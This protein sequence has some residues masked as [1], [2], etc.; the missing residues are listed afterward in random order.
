M[1]S[2]PGLSDE[3]A[4]ITTLVSQ[5][6]A[7]N[8]RLRSRARSLLLLHDGATPAEVTHETSTSRRS[9]LDL[10][11]R[12]R[13]GGLCSALL[14]THPSSEGRMWLTLSPDGPPRV[15]LKSPLT[16]TKRAV[17]SGPVEVIPRH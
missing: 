3:Q 5:N 2:F 12:F 13:S 8:S 16:I 15:R 11:Q 10:I 7:A 1:I 4:L 14:G 9:I 17:D 6:P